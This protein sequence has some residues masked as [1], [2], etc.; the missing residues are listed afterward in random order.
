MQD[1]GAYKSERISKKEREARRVI[2]A[3]RNKDGFNASTQY[4]HQLWLR[5]LVFSED[6]LLKLGYVDDVEKHLSRFIKLQ[7][8]SGQMP[9][10]IDHSVSRWMHQTFQ[11]CLCD[12]EIL[13]VIGMHKFAAVAGN[14][15]LEEN[16]EAVRSCVKF[17]EGRLNEHGFIPGM[18]WRDAMPVYVGKCLL[19]NQMLLADMY[20]VLGDFKASNSIKENVNKLFYL[21]DLGLYADAVYWSEGELKQDRHFDSLG[22]ALAVLNSTA[23]GKT[24]ESILK[25][26]KAAKTGFGYRNIIPY[27]EFDREKA[28]TTWYRTCRVPFGVAFRNRPSKY[29]N[30]TIWPFIEIRVIDALR[31]LHAV[32]EAEAAI[33]R[34]I[35]R[36]R[37]NEYYDPTTGAPEGSVG[38]L[39]T[40]AATLSAIDHY[41]SLRARS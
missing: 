14:G 15:F 6:V 36:R 11:P 9:T 26:L 21:D 33:D 19:A 5:D 30:S 41:R 13:F 8:R 24:S 34:M 25:G 40:A 37:F 39:W 4:Y 28:L 10:V 22:N 18:D 27:Y 32:H 12:T 16:K 17:L 35:E 23:S 7:R 3:C 38:Q 31:K 20:E 2:E 1:P 29:Q